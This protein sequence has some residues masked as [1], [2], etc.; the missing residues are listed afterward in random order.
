[1]AIDWSARKALALHWITVAGYRGIGRREIART[2]RAQGFRFSNEEASR[3][4]REGAGA[5]SRVSSVIRVP[6][7]KRISPDLY[8]RSP[9]VKWSKDLRYTVRVE[10]VHEPTGR[11]WEMYNSV[12]SDKPLTPR[13]IREMATD[14]VLKGIASPNV[15]VRRAVQEE[16]WVREGFIF[17]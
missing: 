5:K 9:G 13:E 4:W 3:A 11:R 17:D 10:L 7:N 2:L 8:T 15:R 14:A 12:T 1:M 16:A 6:L